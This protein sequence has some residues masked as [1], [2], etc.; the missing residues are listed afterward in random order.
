MWKL[1]AKSLYNKGP[2]KRLWLVNSIPIDISIIIKTLWLNTIRG[3]YKK[4]K[5]L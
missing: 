2:Y 4:E 1:V 3:L 5:Y